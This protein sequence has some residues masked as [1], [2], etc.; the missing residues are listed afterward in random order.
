MFI[1]VESI[2][3]EVIIMCALRCNMFWVG[4]LLLPSWD[5][6]EA[7]GNQRVSVETN[8][9][10]IWRRTCNFGNRKLQHT[11]SLIG[12]ITVYDEAYINLAF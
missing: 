11:M 7:I 8:G 4:D 12:F 3:K 5:I 10:F 2:K 1:V 9:W 6:L